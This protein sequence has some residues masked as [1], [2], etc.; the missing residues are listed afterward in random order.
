MRIL[1]TY[2]NVADTEDEELT[3]REQRRSPGSCD[4]LLE[5]PNF[6]RWR[7]KVALPN[8][9]HPRV[10]WLSGDPGC[11]KS[12]LAARVIS[13][14]RGRGYDSSVFFI[15][16]SDISKQ[17]IGNLLKSIAYQMAS[18]SASLRQE[19]LAMQHQDTLT[20]EPTDS[21]AIW[22]QLFVHRVFRAE[23]EKHQ[24][25]IIDALDEAKGS[26]ELFSLLQTLP[27]KYSVFVTSKKDRELEREL[28]RLDMRITTYQVEREDTIQDIRTYLEHSK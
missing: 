20:A 11:G 26:H 21:R 15:K 9:K 22:K 24:Y 3:R 1:A 16:H 14:L 18:S 28:R 4:W 25:W 27:E 5:K 17:S 10:Y 12:Y 19:L 7:D 2:L 13:H 8:E 23:P 6:T